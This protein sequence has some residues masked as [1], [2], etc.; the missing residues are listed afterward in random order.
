MVTV[1]NPAES[2]DAGGPGFTFVDTEAR[3]GVPAIGV[4]H[5]QRT[6]GYHD[7]QLRATVVALMLRLPRGC[8]SRAGPQ[9]AGVPKAYP[10][11]CV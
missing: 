4:H 11:C 10:K 2:R 8:L 9:P 6:P 3:A 5:D 7:E 1:T